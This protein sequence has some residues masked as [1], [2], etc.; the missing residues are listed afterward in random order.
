MSGEAKPIVISIECNAECKAVQSR[1]LKFTT[2]T[3]FKKLDYMIRDF[4]GEVLGRTLDGND[5]LT[6]TEKGQNREV[7][8]RWLL[9]AEDTNKTYC[10]NVTRSSNI[11]Y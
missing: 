1:C 7:T 10:V 3:K 4:V 11:P 2:K 8:I 9:F 5:D 6:I